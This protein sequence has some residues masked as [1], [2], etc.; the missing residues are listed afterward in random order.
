MMQK[1]PSQ[2]GFVTMIIIIV[3]I[4][5]AVIYFAYTRVAASQ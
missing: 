4:L 2:Q 5:A 3:I 1:Q